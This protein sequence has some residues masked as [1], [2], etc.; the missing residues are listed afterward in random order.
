MPWVRTD[1]ESGISEKVSVRQLISRLEGRLEG[2]YLDPLLAIK[3]VKEAAKVGNDLP[4]R[5][6]FAVYRWRP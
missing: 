6:P 5:T 4:L 1:K 2:N 3:A